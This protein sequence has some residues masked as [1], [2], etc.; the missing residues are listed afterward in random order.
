[1]DIRVNVIV[2]IFLNAPDFF[3]TKENVAFNLVQGSI[4]DLFWIDP[5]LFFS[6]FFVCYAV[7]MCNYG[8]LNTFYMKLM[9]TIQ[10]LNLLSVI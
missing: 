9:L 7:T 4:N 1:M 6:L 3:C 8:S 2:W 5:N 10:A